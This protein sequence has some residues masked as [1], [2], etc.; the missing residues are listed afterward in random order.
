M[1]ALQLQMKDL[2]RVS[3]D[4]TSFEIGGKSQKPK[5]LTVAGVN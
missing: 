5:A 4:T 3:S 2:E 1:N